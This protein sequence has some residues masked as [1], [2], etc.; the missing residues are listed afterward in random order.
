MTPRGAGRAAGLALVAWLGTVATAAAH[1]LPG[2]VLLLSHRDDELRL[3][4]Q[5]A[6]DDL[7]LAAPDVRDLEDLPVG[8]NL[9]AEELSRLDAYLAG[10]V[11]LERGAAALPLSLSSASLVPA[12]NDH[13]GA[14]TLVVTELSAPL[15]GTADVSPLTLFYD[16]VMHEIRR[17]D[18]TVYWVPSGAPPL[19]VAEFRYGIVD[20][21][22]RPVP[23]EMPRTD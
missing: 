7:I 11:A 17:H 12:A 5:V 22:P 15:P 23:L 20:G 2:S 13:V 18:A 16:A 1:A 19:P 6:L 8:R 14:F 10:H 21:R 3:T 9:P 4:L